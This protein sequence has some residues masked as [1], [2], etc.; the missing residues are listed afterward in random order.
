MKYRNK[1]LLEVARGQSCML[2][3]PGVCNGNN[4]TVVA[5][6]S[7]QLAHG[8]GMGTKAHDCF[9]AWGCSACHAAIDSGSQLSYEQ[10]KD[11]WQR[12]HEL[13]LLAMF[14]AGMLE[15]VK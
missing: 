10:K 7:N 1:R 5:C 9:V 11:Y 4:E 13:T 3:I 15:V 14:E 2:Q 12:G 6:H 8:K